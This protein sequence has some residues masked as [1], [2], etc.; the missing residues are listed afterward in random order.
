MYTK[1]VCACAYI[2]LSDRFVGLGFPGIRRKGKLSKDQSVAADG[3]EAK[4]IEQGICTQ[5]VL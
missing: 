2:A 4:R 3:A 1:S 5:Y